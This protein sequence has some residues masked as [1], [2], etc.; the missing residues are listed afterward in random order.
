MNNGI[1][2]AS[3]S[4]ERPSSAVEQSLGSVPGVQYG[5]EAG[6]APSKSDAAGR[7]NAAAG[8]APKSYLEALIQARK[9]DA[10]VRNNP[11]LA[12]GVAVLVG[13]MLGRRRRVAI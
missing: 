8:A 10:W 9:A 7:E 2:E 11:W 1:V 3:I 6:M 4:E 13:G 12:V 5:Q